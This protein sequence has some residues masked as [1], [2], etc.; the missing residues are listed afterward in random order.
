MYKFPKDKY[1]MKKYFAYKEIEN[2]VGGNESKVQF[3]N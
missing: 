2:I 3:Q 1:V